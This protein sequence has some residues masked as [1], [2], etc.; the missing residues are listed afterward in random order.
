M[1]LYRE[2]PD[3]RLF[4]NA[5]LTLG[6][7]DGVHLGHRRIFTSVVNVARQKGGDP[8][9]VT[10]NAHPRKVLTPSTPPRILTTADEKLRAIKECGIENI[11]MLDFTPR[12]AGMT[13]S[14]FFNEIVLGR[15]GVIDVVVGYDHA[16]GRD[17]EGTIDFLRELSRTR[18]FAVT[19]VEPKNHQ[20]RPISST[21][22]RT[23]IEDGNMMLASELL[24]RRYS[25]SGRV[26]HGA[27]RGGKRLGFP[28]ANTVPDDPDKV[29]PRD[30][31]YA[32]YVTIEHTE[33]HQGM[34]NIGTN[35]TFASTERTI[36]V[37]IFDFERDIYC[38]KIEIEFVDR[39]RDEIKFD[40]VDNLIGQIQEDRRRILEILNPGDNY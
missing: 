39:I 36:E 34:L 12:M 38:N 6:S 33:K 29:I 19:R 30:G 10:F 2:I 35:P 20:A 26:E 40:S 8:V 11:I 4:K 21:W 18:G 37:N 3:R 28:T 13:A 1:T 16:F 31:V 22:I 5:V 25:L 27:G 17:R 32:V 14:E 15:L 7:F 24:G 9:V 23:E